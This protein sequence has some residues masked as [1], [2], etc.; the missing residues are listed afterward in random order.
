MSLAASLPPRGRRGW[1][2]LLSLTLPLAVSARVTTAAEAPASSQ[3][4]RA[5]ELNNQGVTAAHA[6]HFEEGV[7]LLRQALALNPADATART[8]LSGILTD[9]A[10]QLDARGRSDDAIAALEEA[11]RL[12]DVNGLA[13]VSLGDL[14]YLRRSDMEAAIRWW[15]R[16]NGHVPTTVWQ[17]VANRI[18]QAQRDQ[19]I[20]RHFGATTTAHFAIRFQRSQAADAT[21]LGQLLEAAYT[22]LERQL[23]GG[24]ARLAVIV[25]TD[26]DLRRT[27]NQRDWALGFYDGRIRLRVDDLT[28]PYLPDMIAHELAHAFLH[29]LYQDRLPVW[30]HEG[31]AQLQERPRPVEGEA[32]RIEEGLRSR[33]LWI[34]LKWLDRRFQQPSGAED[35][36]RA[37]TEARLVVQE[38]VSRY[39]MPRLTSFFQQVAAGASVEAAYD[40]AFAPSRWVR[41]DLGDFN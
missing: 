12:D 4:S 20:E 15:Q 29:H 21:R 23:G 14:L 34:P 24:P 11:V 5:T 38:L 33:M 19:L 41:A 32:A 39:G 35:V 10:R 1:L 8:N 2:V 31:F 16:A 17:G 18:T 6:G 25:Y 30:A 26:Q 36:A 40:E 7:A 3:A 22:S 13:L 28:Q 27:Y 37:Y 9:W